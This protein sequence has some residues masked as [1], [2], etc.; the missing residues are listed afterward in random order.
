MHGEEWNA[1]VSERMKGRLMPQNMFL[2][3]F[4]IC[5]REVNI[6]WKSNA[7]V[8]TDEPCAFACVEEAFSKGCDHFEEPVRLIDKSIKQQGPT[9]HTKTN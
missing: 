1:L 3:M 4:A 7:L 8:L 2:S 9:Q 5:Y 6:G